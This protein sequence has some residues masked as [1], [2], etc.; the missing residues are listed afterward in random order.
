M[1][2]GYIATTLDGYIADNAGSVSFLDNFSHID[3]GYDSF[4][5]TIDVIIMG[6]SSY[7]AILGFDIEW[8]YPAQKT[9]VIT[10][11]QTLKTPHENI[12]LWHGDL[13]S[14]IKHLS[15]KENEN[16]WFLGGGKLIMDAIQKDLLDRLELFIMPVILG[17]GIPLFPKTKL[18]IKPLKIENTT[19]IE[20]SIN[21]CIYQF[22][23]TEIKSTN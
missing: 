21:H 14:L 12:Q 1:N 5:E 2:I 23:S 18:S 22:N 7:E 16:C 9:W 13:E 3:T 17:E 19:L 4:I 8:P 10:K 15:L 6:R 20:T 11:D